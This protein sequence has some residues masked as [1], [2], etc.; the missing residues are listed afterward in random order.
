V[1]WRLENLDRKVLPRVVLAWEGIEEEEKDLFSMWYSF[2]PCNCV[3][4]VQVGE[5]ELQHLALV[6]VL[7]AQPEN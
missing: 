4:N 7:E 6:K 1:Y 3:E 2:A 5:R